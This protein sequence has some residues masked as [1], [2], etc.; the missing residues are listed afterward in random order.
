MARRSGDKVG[1]VF[2]ACLLLCAGLIFM[3]FGAGLQLPKSVYASFNA[4]VRNAGNTFAT[5]ALSAGNTPTADNSTVQTTVNLTWTASSGGSLIEGYQIRSYN[6]ATSVERVVG[7]SCSGIIA[8]TN[9]SETS[10]PDGNWKYTVTARQQL[11]SGPE[12]GPSNSIFIDT[13]A[14][15]PPSTPDMTSGTDS[16]SSSSDNIT[17]DNTP[18][19]AGTAEAGSTVTIYDG[20]TS[21]GSGTA[22][23]GNYSI[24]TSAL[25][26][27]GRTITAK[28]ADATG[29]VSGASAGLSVTIDTAAP[30]TPS[31]P[32]LTTDSGISSTDNIT[33]VTTPTFAGTAEA[34][35]TVALFDEVLSVGTGTATGG[36]YSV[37]TSTLI[38]GSHT[39]TAKSTDAAGNVS[40]TSSGLVITV[41]TI[42][43]LTLL[44]PDLDAASDSGTLSTDNITNIV[45]PSFSGIGAETGSTVTIY[46]GGSS[47][48]SAAAGGTSYTVPTSGI[49]EG[50]R[51]I[52]ARSIDAAGNASLTSLGL[53]VVVDTTAPTTINTFPA[54]SFYNNTT[55]AAGCTSTVCGTASDSNTITSVGV[56]VRQGTGNY[57]NA[58][59]FGS[60]TEVL[61]TAVGTTSW[62]RAFLATSFPAEGLYTVRSV[63]TDV[64]GNVG[65]GTST[66]FTIDRTAP[67]ASDIQTTN[68]SGG[69]NGM[70]ELGDTVIFTYSEQLNP[71]SILAGWNG[72]SQAAVIRILDGGCTLVLC[73]DDSF[74]MET[75]GG[76]ALP[77]GSVNLSRIDYNGD[78]IGLGKDADLVF[79]AT[80]VRSGSGITI[81]LGSKTLGSANTAGGNATMSWSSTT[82]PSD[83]AGN[84]ATGNTV[85]ESGGADKEF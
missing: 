7:A 69:T 64:A 83:R 14:P 47:I 78:G 52:T 42:A 53:T 34:N 24:T 35:S 31:V 55:W 72:T 62:T 15:S 16:G 65:A 74:S 39:I 76:A 58:T 84:P 19:F 46:D 9:C 20:V 61:A 68:V 60:A 73:S 50:S 32:D 4:V 81:T 21:V 11:W 30:A 29:N 36:N 6:S 40:A 49:G 44:A 77:F 43:P 12:S 63:G 2:R 51:T 38:D 10:V 8:A 79:N 25:S 59:T 17:N 85:N 66:T 56:S 45:T 48:G 71:A 18:T 27:G 26:D 33:N 5:A 3:A 67:A 70:A 1:E 75:T 23:G 54:A 28:A 13:T 57:W 22:T 37:S 80:M 82:T 41:D